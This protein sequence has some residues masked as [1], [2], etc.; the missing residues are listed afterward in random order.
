MNFDHFSRINPTNHFNHF[1]STYDNERKLYDLLLTEAY[2]KHGL[3]MTYFAI[4]Y[5]TSYDRIFGEDND[6]RIMRKFDFQ[7]YME[8]LPSETKN[9]S[10]FGINTTDVIKGF[11][12]KSHFAVA[13]TYDENGPY[14]DIGTSGTMPSIKPRA[15][16]IVRLSLNELEDPYRQ[17][18]LYEENPAVDDFLR[19]ATMNNTYFEII[20]VKEQE[21]QFMQH[22]H[23]WDI[24]MR[25]YRDKSLSLESSASSSFGDLTQYVDKTDIFDIGKYITEAVEPY[26]NKNDIL[27]KQA[28]TEC[29][30]K[31]PH[32]DWWSD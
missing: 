28:Q 21:V 17:T 22:Q 8:E 6:R 32:N 30:P 7:I 12:S 27:Y 25:V 16:D 2:N 15:G 13:S 1:N 11:V 26:T 29:P 14:D 18:R 31:D 4:T 3:S 9:F 20:S 23:T 5:D 24:T 19:S 10:A